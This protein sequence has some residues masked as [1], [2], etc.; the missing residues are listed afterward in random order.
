MGWGALDQLL[1]PLEKHLWAPWILK[2]KQYRGE[3][4]PGGQSHTNEGQ[5]PGEAAHWLQTSSTSYDKAELR[6][7]LR[8]SFQPALLEL[9]ILEGL[10]PPGEG[11]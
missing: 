6:T 11:T 10:G 8:G 4:D 9:Y 3:E 2:G 7:L 5:R 1:I